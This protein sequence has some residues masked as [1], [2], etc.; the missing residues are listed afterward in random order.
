[1]GPARYHCAKLNESENSLQPHLRGEIAYLV[2][3]SGRLLSSRYLRPF[4]FAHPPHHYTH[5]HNRRALASGPS[6]KQ[7]NSP[8][9]H[10][11]WQPPSMLDS[12]LASRTNALPP[13]LPSSP[14]ASL[15]LA[16]PPPQ[17]WT[18]N[19]LSPMSVLPSMPPRSAATPRGTTSSVPRAQ[20]RDGTSIL[21]LW[22][23]SGKAAASSEPVSLTVSKQHISATPLCPTC[24]SIQISPRTWPRDKLHGAESWP[25][26]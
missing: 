5:T 2:G 11:P 6:N 24:W 8:S 4:N 22:R 12:S 19:S 16:T 17:P 15:L 18:S 13:R 23:A 25:W 20:K 1:M 7:R 10:P 21:D 3:I 14:P 26:R 9:Q